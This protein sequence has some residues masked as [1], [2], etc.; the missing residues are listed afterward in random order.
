MSAIST[1]ARSVLSSRRLMMSVGRGSIHCAQHSSTV[2]IGKYPH[3]PYVAEKLE[4]KQERSP[5]PWI[6]LAK[7]PWKG[8]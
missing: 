5:W 2:R 6:Q 8:R 7:R 1:V 4:A 3:R